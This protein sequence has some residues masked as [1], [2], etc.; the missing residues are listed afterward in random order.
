MLCKYMYIPI[1][2]KKP[3]IFIIDL[4]SPEVSVHTCHFAL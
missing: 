3:T 1:L 4:T 2:L